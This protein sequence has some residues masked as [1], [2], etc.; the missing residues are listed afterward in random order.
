MS[1]EVNHNS[2]EVNEEKALALLAQAHMTSGEARRKLAKQ[3]LQ[4]DPNSPDA[5]NILASYS[6]HAKEAEQLYLMGLK[7]GEEKIGQ[8]CFSENKGQFWGIPHAR[9]YM[10][11]KFNYGELLASLGRI[12]ESIIQYRQL[13]LLN[14]AD[15]QEARYPLFIIYIEAGFISE[16]DLLLQQYNTSL[17]VNQMFN[18]ILIAYYQAGITSELKNELKQANA[19]YPDV[20]GYLTRKEIESSDT[21][22]EASI[23]GHM[24]QHL[25]EAIPELITL[26]NNND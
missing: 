14:N 19:L 21:S 22:T 20:A 2:F 15:D 23:Y 16:A 9:P 11:V 26:L 12:K 10:Q 13:L 18:R 25:W 8:A 17:T 3:A 24:H 4:F 7:A 5:F 6:L 1:H